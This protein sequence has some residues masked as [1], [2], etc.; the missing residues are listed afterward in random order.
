MKR[1][2]RVGVAGLGRIF[3][4]HARGYEQS[5]D[6]EIVALFDRDP[7]QVARH[8][9]QFPSAIACPTYEKLLEQDLDLVEILSPHAYHAEQAIAA[10]NRGIHV[11]VQKPM[12]LTLDEA[13]RMIAAANNSGRN[14]RVFE[15]FRFYAPLAKARQLVQEGAIGRPLH[16]RLRTVAGD[17]SQAWNVDASTWRWRA[18]LFEKSKI[19]R[20]TF[21]D[22][23]H[24]LA[25]AIWFFGPVE[26]VFARIDVTETPNGLIDAPASI[27]WR[28]VDPPVHV[29]WDVVYAPRLAIRTDYY[30]LDER[31]EITGELGIIT[32]TR[33]TGR[34]LDEPVL[35]LYRD[36]EV[37][38]FHG[39]ESDWGASFVAAT[40]HHIKALLHDQPPDMSAADGRG[41]LEL[42]LAVARSAANRAPVTMTSHP[43]TAPGRPAASE[44][45]GDR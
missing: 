33:A 3:P 45:D 13:D 44:R 8:Q 11:S 38:A 40:H 22:G 15:N 31:F 7:A 23:H 2:L 20:L 30:A 16:C 9:A 39:L 12:A 42:A 18:E 17:P 35:T 24:K 1:V 6:A 14:L 29:I 21:D 41:V 43:T 4:L 32:V 27:S 28:H 34:M 37:R 26:E 25:T 19:G 36:G 5:S 10:L